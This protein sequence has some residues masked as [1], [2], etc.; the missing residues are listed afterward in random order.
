[1]WRTTD[2]GN[3]YS[4]SFSPIYEVP[5]N[6][7]GEGGVS[8]E[9]KAKCDYCGAEMEDE[10]GKARMLV[11]WVIDKNGVEAYS[12]CSP[13]CLEAFINSLMGRW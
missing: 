9:E 4:V 2:M 6:R 3:Y 7:R 8:L 11:L 10:I 5:R 12:F 1:M 13:K